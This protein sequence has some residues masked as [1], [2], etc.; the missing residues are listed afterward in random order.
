MAKS[1]A[2]NS[3]RRTVTVYL[4]AAVLPTTRSPQTKARQL[5]SAVLRLEIGNDPQFKSGCSW[6]MES[7]N[8]DFSK[9]GTPNLESSSGSRSSRN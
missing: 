1:R 9:Y 4:P 2:L 6:E 5:A 8:V 3:T 7:T